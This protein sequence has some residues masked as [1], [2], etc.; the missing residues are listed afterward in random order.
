M[1][2]DLEGFW[3]VLTRDAAG[4]LKG[5]GGAGRRLIGPTSRVRS[6]PLKARQSPV[7]LVVDIWL[8]LGRAVSP[9]SKFFPRVPSVPRGDRESDGYPLDALLHQKAVEVENVAPSEL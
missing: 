3:G 7:T 9:V 5:G 4:R 8:R 6:G 2:P 1:S